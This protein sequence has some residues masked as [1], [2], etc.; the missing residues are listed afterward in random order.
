MKFLVKQIIE[1]SKEIEA[2]TK[3]EALEYF[4]EKDAGTKLLK[5]TAK[6]LTTSTLK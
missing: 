1:L 6:K 4:S 3:E 5:F 2:N